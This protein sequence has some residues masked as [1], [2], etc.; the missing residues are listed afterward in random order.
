M[1]RRRDVNKFKHGCVLVQRAIKVNLSWLLV[2]K[3]S[4]CVIDRQPQQQ[5]S[6]LLPSTIPHF[7]SFS[8]PP[9]CL[10]PAALHFHTSIVIK[11]NLI[12]SI[13]CMHTYAHS[14]MHRS[15]EALL[16]Q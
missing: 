9:S 3:V 12:A 6:S 4:S 1:A 14:H 8:L 2:I 10:L 16:V 5:A 11:H 15:D 13:T 7:C